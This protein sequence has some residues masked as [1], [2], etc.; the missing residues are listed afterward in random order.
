MRKAL[1]ILLSLAAAGTLTACTAASSEQR[2]G[3]AEGYGGPLT[4]SVTTDG[5]K[6]TAVKV[7][8]HSETQGV[9]TRAIDALPDEIVSAGTWD[10][11][12]V[13]GATVTSKAIKEA[14]ATAMGQGASGDPATATDQSETQGQ[15]NSQ[16][17]SATRSGFGMSAMGR[18]GP[19]QDDQGNPVYSF[20]VVFAHGTFDDQGRIVSVGVD[21]LEV[22]TPNYDGASMPHFSGWP[23]QGGYDHYDDAQGKV[24]GKTDDTEDSFMTEVSAW[25]TKRGR[26]EDYPMGTGTWETQMNA[27]QE[28]FQGK[29]VEELE[30]WFSTLFSDS[31][32]RPLQQDS[33]NA[34]DQ[35]KYEALSDAQKAELADVTSSA[36]MSLEDAH[37]GILTAIRRAW[38][39][40]QDSD[41]Q[42]DQQNGQQNDSSNNQ[43]NNQQNG[44]QSGDTQV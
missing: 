32:G 5:G 43:Q 36:T 33:S 42:N 1:L 35:K 34:D 38:E 13:S 23:G 21:Q 11:D 28:M 8:S 7:L 2:V 27:Y 4:V 26:G 16:S 41:K 39:D 20:N 6:I 10:V 31:T 44:Q 12:N 24:S 18:I 25:Q 30:Q 17:Q 37:G 14:V 40:A 19:G 3:K 9:G 29:T 22:A 15:S